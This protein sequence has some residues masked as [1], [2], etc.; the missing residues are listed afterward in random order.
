MI[1]MNPTH[2]HYSL[3]TL[4]IRAGMLRSELGEHS[5]AIYPT[6]S[7]V[8]D[9]AADAAARFAGDKPGYMYS[10][11]TNPSV[12]I[13]EDRLAALEG[14]EACI[15][16][17]SGMAAIHA[18][19]MALTKQG[20][21][22]ITSGSVFGTTLNLFNQFMPKFGVNCTVV[23]SVDLAE[24]KKAVTPATKLLFVET[25][26]NPTADIFDIR[27]L[28]DI[29]H[30]VGAQLVVDNCFCT[31]ILQRPLELGA[32]IVMHS[33]TKHLDGQGRV[34]GGAIVGSEQLCKETLYAY[35]RTT[36][37]SLSPFNA[38]VLSKG[39]ELLPLRMR[40][41]SDNALKVAEFL[42]SHPNVAKVNYPFLGSHPQITLAKAQQSG[43]G[44]VL[45]FAVKGGR[46]E[47]WKVID[48]TQMISITANLGDVKST[49][50]HPATT[51]HLR[52][53]EAQRLKAGI[54]QDLLRV[55]V[56]L[57]NPDDIISDL[58]RG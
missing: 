3:D 44:A 41:H 15:A 31:P 48:Q 37:A 5:E 33:A 14:G 8:Y 4:A 19:A 52:M 9:N 30:S 42:A 58:A 17:A 22:I 40:A 1:D 38:W 2:P 50:T 6:I 12:T 49:I 13:F 16:V 57:E 27:G 20:D 35:L 43:G 46:A 55:A 51:T 25:P 28:A 47:A 23:N 34:M 18:L 26:S 39:L 36:G 56:G 24:W 54:D 53:P 29:A 10:R 45:S 11:F 7:F 21:H 32:D